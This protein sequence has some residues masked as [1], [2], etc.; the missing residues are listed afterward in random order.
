MI[1]EEAIRI[2]IS[3]RNDF[4]CES[5]TMVD[6]CNTVIDALEQTKWIPVNKRLPECGKNV[7]AIN[8][9]KDIAVAWV[10]KNGVWHSY[11][12]LFDCYGDV[13]AWMPLPK[14]Y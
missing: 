3:L 10:N 6:F 5:A 2:A 8:G 12:K 13:G 7:I 4:K 1:R 14:I 11:D 9:Y